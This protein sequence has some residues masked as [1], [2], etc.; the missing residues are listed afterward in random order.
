MGNIAEVLKAEITR[1]SRR[2]VKAAIKALVKSNTSLKRTVADLKR[3]LTEFEKDNRRLKAK[4]KK[5][6][7]AEPEKTAEESKK[8]RL[9]SKGIRS[10]RSKLGLKRPDFAKL[11]G[12]TA[13]TVYM[14]ERKGG[15]LRLRENTKA[16]ILAVRD[17]GAREAKKRLAGAN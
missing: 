8:A 5:E 2:E 3:R 1:V 13:Q 6:Q 12:T 7:S 17:L 16:A 15:A 10:L 9:T 14:W 11:V 4:E